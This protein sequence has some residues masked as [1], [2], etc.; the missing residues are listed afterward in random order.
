MR[1]FKIYRLKGLLKI[2]LEKELDILR[3]V[4]VKG[5]LALVI[6]VKIKFLKIVSLKIR[7]EIILK[8]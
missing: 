1:Q 3:K 8:I 4:K 7:L 2:R 5:I 6:F